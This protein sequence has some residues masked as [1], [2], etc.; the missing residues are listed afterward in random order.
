MGC[1]TFIVA[2]LV[3]VSLHGAS[4]RMLAADAGKESYVRADLSQLIG[5][6]RGQNQA[7]LA[8]LK[9][10]L[11]RIGYLDSEGADEFSDEFNEDLEAALRTYQSE[12]QRSPG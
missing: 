4:C 10:Y 7:A 2:I 6:R 1:S 3:L 5:C 8:S 9:R 11:N 12:H